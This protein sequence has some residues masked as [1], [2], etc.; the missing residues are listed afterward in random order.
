VSISVIENPPKVDIQLSRAT[1]TY[2]PLGILTQKHEI[3]Q[4]R[5]TDTAYFDWLLLALVT[6]FGGASARR[7]ALGR[8]ALT[9]AI[10][11]RI[12]ALGL[13]V[14]S[15]RLGEPFHLLTSRGAWASGFSHEVICGNPSVEYGRLRAQAVA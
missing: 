4:N 11:K 9:M 3:C 2:R 13:L 15:A 7:R 12:L 8:R 14:A 6:R 5:H 10:M 1:N